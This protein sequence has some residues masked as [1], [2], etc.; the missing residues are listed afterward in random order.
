MAA[1]ILY[2]GDEGGPWKE[3]SNLY[4]ACNP[5]N[6]YTIAQ[7]VRE[8]VR[9]INLECKPFDKTIDKAA[10]C[11]GLEMVCPWPPGADV[12][13]VHVDHHN[14]HF[15]KLLQLRIIYCVSDEAAQRLIE[16]IKTFN[17][18]PRLADYIVLDMPVNLFPP[19]TAQVL[20]NRGKY[21]QEL[22]FR[23]NGNLSDV[24]IE[25]AGGVRG[26]QQLV[27]TKRFHEQLMRGRMADFKKD[28]CELV[29]KANERVNWPLAI[30][31]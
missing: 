28:F 10:Y 24:I 11:N 2:L 6:A 5:Q 29:E 21:F 9:K 20:S 15:N 3:A 13:S 23:Y 4:I 30:M 27:V 26:E 31:W 25:N 8:V 1:S 16:Y 7:A 17:S 12:L 18:A 14:V 22:V 19:V